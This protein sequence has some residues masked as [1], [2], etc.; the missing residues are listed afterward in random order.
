[1]N[2]PTITITIDAHGQVNPIDPFLL[3]PD[4]IELYFITNPYTIG[5]CSKRTSDDLKNEANDGKNEDKWIKPYSLAFNIILGKIDFGNYLPPPLLKKYIA[6]KNKEIVKIYETEFTTQTR[7][8]PIGDNGT[9][10]LS[11]I[12]EILNKYEASYKII[13]ACCMDDEKYTSETCI[14]LPKK[15]EGKAYTVK[16]YFP[17]KKSIFKDNYTIDINNIRLL[18]SNNYIY[19]YIDDPIIREEI[20][21][22]PWGSLVD[23]FKK[24][25]DKIIIYGKNSKDSIVLKPDAKPN[26]I[27]EDVSSITFIPNSKYIRIIGD[28]IVRESEWFE[29]FKFEEKKSTNTKSF[30]LTRGAIPELQIINE[31]WS[32][33]VKH[34]LCSN[35]EVVHK[36]NQLDFMK[37]KI[38]MCENNNDKIMV[39][40]YDEVCDI[41]RKL[42]NKPGSRNKSESRKT[43][44][45]PVN[46]KTNNNRKKSVNNKTNNNR[47]KSVNNK[48]NNN[49]KKSDKSKLPN[50][51]RKNPVNGKTFN[52]LIKE[53]KF[54]F[55]TTTE[56]NFTFTYNNNKKTTYKPTDSLP[57]ENDLKDILEIKITWE[58]EK[59]EDKDWEFIL[60]DNKKNYIINRISKINNSVNGNTVNNDKEEEVI[61]VFVI[62]DEY[63]KNMIINEISELAKKYDGSNNNNARK[64]FIYYIN[65]K[66]L[67]HLPKEGEGYKNKPY[68][69]FTFIY[70]NDKRDDKTYRPYHLLPGGDDL[71]DISEIKITHI[72]DYIHNAP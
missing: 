11:D 17:F 2:N 19:I 63:T 62:K 64:N 18:T 9:G 69:N 61:K 72:P 36:L 7:T 41:M 68:F 43:I 45:K 46:N 4:N 14:F 26:K 35:N 15:Y 13:I 25:I 57:G 70:K 16:N 31:D 40:S 34:K 12:L 65:S 29:F 71:E 6:K 8:M 28:N 3:V 21:N 5:N 49:R 10:L 1:M 39:F 54:K 59:I 33:V 23:N 27:L 32:A 60:D 56:L 53:G 58:D 42:G 51:N 38:N 55:P 52:D 50:N 20:K 44:K 48:T 37:S 66:F 67:E 30:S 47:K 22:N 24:L